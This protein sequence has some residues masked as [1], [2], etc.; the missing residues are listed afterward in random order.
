MANRDL[1]K[2]EEEGRVLIAKHS[3]YG[4]RVTEL[5]AIKEVAEEELAKGKG[6]YNALFSLIAHVYNIGL[7]TGYRMAKADQKKQ[8]KVA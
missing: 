4:L 5:E 7:A 2:L 6:I 1:D 8:K 3:G